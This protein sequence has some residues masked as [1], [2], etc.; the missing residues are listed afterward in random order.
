MA[1]EEWLVKHINLSPLQKRGKKCQAKKE[2]ADPRTAKADPKLLQVWDEE[3]HEDL[4]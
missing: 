4:I 2:N 3:L 1:P